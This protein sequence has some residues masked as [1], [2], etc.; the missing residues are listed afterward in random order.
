MG[1][2]SIE[3]D[4]AMSIVHFVE[5]EVDFDRKLACGTNTPQNHEIVLFLLQLETFKYPHLRTIIYFKT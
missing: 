4:S 5:S 1:N 2:K 3:N